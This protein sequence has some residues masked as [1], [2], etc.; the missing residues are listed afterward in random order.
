M[1]LL[2]PL[3]QILACRFV[4]FAKHPQANAAFLVSISVWGAMLLAPFEKL[5]GITRDSAL[6]DAGT[7]GLSFHD[8]VR[9]GRVMAGVAGGGAASE[10][11][12]HASSIA[13]DEAE[14]A[15]EKRD[16]LIKYCNV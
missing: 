2:L 4:F 6:E 9:E 8:A 14:T 11:V 10:D 15:E 3:L 7:D 1:L 16:Y 5:L 12:L 13:G